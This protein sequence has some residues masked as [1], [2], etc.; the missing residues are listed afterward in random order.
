MMPACFHCKG[1]L[2]DRSQGS[3]SNVFSPGSSLWRTYEINRVGIGG[4]I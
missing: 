4:A 3:P 2:R 1:M